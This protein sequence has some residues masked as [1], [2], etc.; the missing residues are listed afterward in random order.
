MQISIT[1]RHIEVSPD[2]K[3]YVEKQIEKLNKF[4]NHIIRAHV[5]LEVEKFRYGAEIVLTLKKQVL[6]VKEITSN[7]YG[8]VER[9]VKRLEKNLHRFEEKVKLHRKG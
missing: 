1:G 8:S 7:I 6:K 2:L 3:S 5:I 9:A 4:D